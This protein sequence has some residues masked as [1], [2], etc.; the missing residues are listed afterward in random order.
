M[1]FPAPS[2][3]EIQSV[4]RELGHTLPPALLRLYAVRGNGGFGP[5]YGL[6]GIASGHVT[7]LGDT[8][9]SLYRTFYLPDPDAPDWVWPRN[10]LPILHAGC[11]I[12]Y[13]IDLASP[14]NAVIKFDPNGYAPGDDWSGAFT[15]ASPSLEPWLAGL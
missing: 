4:E 13:C 8:A 12:H 1:T 2:D 15:V 6:L 3:N 14:S 10:L 11:G 7:D 9:V 5:P